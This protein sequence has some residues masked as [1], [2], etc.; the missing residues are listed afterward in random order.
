MPRDR[1]QNTE[2]DPYFFL[3]FASEQKLREHKRKGTTCY[4]QKYYCK[5]HPGSAL[6]TYR[7]LE[8]LLHHTQVVHGN[9]N[10]PYP[11]TRFDYTWM[12]PN[13]TDLL[14]CPNQHPELT[15]DDVPY[16]FRSEQ[17][18][19]AHMIEHHMAPIFGVVVPQPPPPPP[20]AVL[21]VVVDNQIAHAPPVSQC[22]S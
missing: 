19:Q 6:W 5:Q 18:R 10:Q 22:I 14:T 17:E 15:T 9:Y 16:L 20:P 8:E 4:A 1:R 21:A 13:N 3:G 11:V 7:T 2:N 12:N